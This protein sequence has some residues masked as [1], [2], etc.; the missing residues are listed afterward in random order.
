MEEN[1]KIDPE[2][3]KH[4]LREQRDEMTAY[5]IYLDIAKVVKEPEN[6]AIVEKIAVN[7]KKH[8][9]WLKIL[10]G[11]DVKQNRW[12]RIFYYWVIRLFGLTFGI[13]LLEKDEIQQI[14]D[15]EELGE[16]FPGFDEIL[17]NG[18]QREQELI[19][20][21]NEERLQY[22]GSVV[23]GLNDALIELVGA[24]AGYTFAFQNTRLIALT[25][26]ITGISGSLSM[27]ASRYLSARQEGGRNAIKDMI[28]SGSA[29][30]VTVLAMVIPFFLF[31]NPFV[32]LVTTFGVAIL[33]IF[34][35]NYYI[36][37]AKDY[38]FRKRFLEMA[39]ISLGVATVSFLI[40]VVIKRYI[41]ID[42]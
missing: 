15:Y 19:A 12:K 4:L 3:R 39:A 37:I 35:F 14:R 33:I 40:G 30:I 41:G 20:L 29:F 25:G 26:L 22:M 2:M 5:R 23:L 34:I 1:R 6:K 36:S 11:R 24:L 21:I 38:V 16:K 7:E 18:E 42:V 31:R 10:T 27:I 17:L 32:S 13:K 28:Y 9:E 8:Y